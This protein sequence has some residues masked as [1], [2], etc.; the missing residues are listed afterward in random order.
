M[1]PN[2]LDSFWQ[3]TI[4]ELAST[5]INVS[6]E[7]LPEQSHREFTTSSVIMHSFQNQRIRGWYSVPNDPPLGGEFPAILA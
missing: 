7:E 2:D 6:L 3:A 5:D 1:R 4:E